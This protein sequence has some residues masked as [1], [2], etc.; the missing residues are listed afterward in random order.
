MGSRRLTNPDDIDEL[1]KLLN[2]LL[3]DPFSSRD[4]YREEGLVLAQADCQ[5]LDVVAPPSEDSSY[6]VYNSALVPNKY[7]DC[8]AFHPEMRCD[9]W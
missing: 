9:G 6:A 8:M 7:Q 4:D 3:Q 5:G 2:D 1:V